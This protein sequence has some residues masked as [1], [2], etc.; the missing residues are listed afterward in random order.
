FK[1]ALKLPRGCQVKD[2]HSQTKNQ[3][4]LEGA[5]TIIKCGYDISIG[6]N[7]TPVIWIKTKIKFIDFKKSQA[8]GELFLID[9]LH[10]THSMTV[11]TDI[12]KL[13]TH[14][15]VSVP[16]LL[17]KIKIFKRIEI[18]EDRMSEIIDNLSEQE[19]FNMD[20]RNRLR[21]LRDYVRLAE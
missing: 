17:K 19:L 20:I 16:S 14:T 21:L 11:L 8:M 5:N 2:V 9:K 3:I 10:P 15:T 6:L 7:A 12:K 1:E 13:I 4:H 18:N